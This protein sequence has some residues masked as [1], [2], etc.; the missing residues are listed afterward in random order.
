MTHNQASSGSFHFKLLQPTGPLSTFVQGVWSASL[1]G[2]QPLTKKLYPDGGSG[3]VFNLQGEVKVAGRVLPKGV[4]MLGTSK[5]ASEVCLSKG[6]V[7]AGVRF[8]PAIGFGILGHHYHEPTLL[9]P[10]EDEHFGLYEMYFALS[11]VQGA[12]E[13]TEVLS[14]WAQQRLAFTHLIPDSLEQVLK[15]INNNDPLGKLDEGAPLSQRQIQ[16]LFKMWLGMTPKYF[17]RILRIQ[18]A[19][20]YLRSHKNACLAAVAQEFGFSDQAHM[21]REFRHI[22]CVT[23]KQI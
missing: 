20:N 10:S 23:P 18:K 17:Q 12:D 5:Q 1:G 6:A 14:Q 3:I 13:Q 4:I 9:L 16:R 2:P 8:H 22:A 19:I 7:L 11:A 21:T 15:H